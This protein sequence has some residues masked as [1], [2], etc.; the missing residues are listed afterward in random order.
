MIRIVFLFNELL[1]EITIVL[2]FGDFRPIVYL[3]LASCVIFE[4]SR[5]DDYFLGKIEIRVVT[6]YE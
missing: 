1:R 4:N 2:D 3:F 6:V 5:D